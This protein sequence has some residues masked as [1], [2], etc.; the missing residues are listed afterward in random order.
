MALL[1]RRSDGP[2]LDLLDDSGRNIRLAATTLGELLGD[3][4]E[5]ADLAEQL[6]RCEH[7]GNRIAHD[8]IHRLNGGRPRGRG[9]PL[10][11]MTGHGLASALDDIVDL[12][13]EAAD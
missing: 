7:E 9:A 13:E 8:I 2:L 1:R 10:H 12:A 6:L 5:R 4:P 3:P 11:P